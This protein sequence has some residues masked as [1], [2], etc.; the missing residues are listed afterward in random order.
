MDKID[1]ILERLKGLQPRL[2]HPE[3]MVERVMDKLPPQENVKTECRPSLVKKYWRWVAVGL[4]FL[5]AGS[6]WLLYQP[7]DN[8]VK[9]IVQAT[10]SM[11]ADSQSES[12]VQGDMDSLIQVSD[13]QQVAGLRVSADE[14]GKERHGTQQPLRLNN[15][16]KDLLLVAAT[17]EVPAE[18]VETSA[19]PSLPTIRQLQPDKQDLHYAS[20][21]LQADSDYVDPSRI[22]DFVMKFANYYHV[23]TVSLDCGMDSAQMDI[24]HLVRVFPDIKE[25]DV[26]GRM[27]KV[28]IS[29]DNQTPG[30]HLNF[31]QQKFYFILHD[32]R[33][34][35]RYL[36]LAE[37]VNGQILLYATHSPINMEMTY[38]CYQKYRA[39]ITQNQPT[40]TM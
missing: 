11:K 23:E 26:F 36:W 27:L 38:D 4:L 25:V 14:H 17:E 32:E 12:S 13:E 40:S 19:S 31:S 3:E 15:G 39:F 16:K 37:R 1:D 24:V 8:H 29:I 10:K 34:G 18:V 6:V 35:L 28:A 5:G 30:Y 21:A 7:K 33:K 22:D 2:S 9:T 20:R